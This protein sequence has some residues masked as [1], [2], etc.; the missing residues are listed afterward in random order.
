MRSVS[1]HL[2][3][4]LLFSALMLARPAGADTDETQEQIF[5]H[6]RVGRGLWLDVRDRIA[7]L[8][9]R[10]DEGTDFGA[11]YDDSELNWLRTG[12]TFKGAL[13]IGGLDQRVAFSLSSAVVKP[14]VDGSTSFLDLPGSNDDPFDPML[15]S[16]FGLGGRF[17]VGYGFSMEVI[18]VYSPW[19]DAEVRQSPQ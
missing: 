10:I 14:I 6:A 15:D 16:A 9:V 18:R 3:F 8:R 19:L 2:G 7:G 13:P 1:I 5:E 11:N 12:L 4:I 17:D